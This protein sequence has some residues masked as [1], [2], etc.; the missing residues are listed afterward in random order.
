MASGKM[1]DASVPPELATVSRA[2]G[3]R[4]RAETEEDFPAIERSSQELVDAATA[5]MAAGYSLTEIAHA[6]TTGK[7]EV[8]DSLSGDALRRVERTGRQARDAQLEHHRSIARAMRLGL[9]TREIA[10]AANVTH[11][12]IRAITNRL[13]ASVPAPA[14]VGDEQ[15]EDPGPA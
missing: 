9:S 15:T 6:E 2:A 5:A 12:T 13:A 8:R 14:A 7:D 10:S 4:L 3:E 11:G 1:D